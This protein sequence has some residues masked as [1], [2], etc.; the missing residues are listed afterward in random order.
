MLYVRPLA[1]AR[2]VN[3]SLKTITNASFSRVTSR[4]TLPCSHRCSARRATSAVHSP[5]G[6][7]CT[8]RSSRCAALV[9]EQGSVPRDVTLSERVGSPSAH[10]L[11]GAART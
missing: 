3:T 5:P 11:I 1:W 8:A 2:C 6:E 7:A 10:V 4:G 9:A